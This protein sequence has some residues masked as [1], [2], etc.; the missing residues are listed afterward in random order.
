M[1]RR[2]LPL[3][4]LLLL[5]PV[6]A[7]ADVNIYD[8]FRD[9]VRKE[10]LEETYDS[11]MVKYLIGV[12]G[13]RWEFDE[14]RMKKALAG[15]ATE[16]CG[17]D[18]DSS[19][20]RP[21]ANGLNCGQAIG[22]IQVLAIEEQELRSF[23]RN[24]Q[25]IAAAQELPLSEIPGRPFHLATD[26]SGII[27]IWRAGTGSVR[28][29]VTGAVLLRTRPLTEDEADRL[30]EVWDQM[31]ERG[32]ADMDL[33]DAVG[34]V[35]WRYQYG[36]RLVKGERN[37]GYPPPHEDDQSGP[38]TERP[39]MFKDWQDGENGEIGW[40]EIL[41]R[42]W[43]LLPKSRDAFDPPLSGNEVAYFLFPDSVQSHMP[44]GTLLWA[45]VGAD[46]YE[47]GVGERDALG[48]VGLVW[49]YP[50]E[51]LLPALL[52]VDRDRFGEPILGGRYPPEPVTD[53][54]SDD[55]GNPL[56]PGEKAPAD[57][58]GLCSM[59]LAQRGYLCRK[60]TVTDEGRC[61]VDENAD[62]GENAISL[63][64]C[65]LEDKPTVTLAG[66]DVC[67]EITWKN[68][69]QPQQCRVEFYQGDCNGADAYAEP[70]TPD[71]LLRV[72]VKGG[73][74]VNLT[75]ILE[76]EL[77]H[78]QQFCSMPPG[79]I[80]AGLDDD[81]AGALCC[82]IEGEAYLANCKRMYDDG[83]LR[84][85]E[86][87]SAYIHGFELTPQICMELSRMKS[88]QAVLGREVKCESSGDFTT[89]DIE[90]LFP[91]LVGNPKNLPD[92]FETSTNPE[93]MDPRIA[94]RVRAIERYNPV[95]TPGTES[96]YKNTI[97][98]NACYVG[99]C[100]EESLETHRVTAGRSPAT[101]GDGAFPWDDPEMG[102]ALATTLR[103]VP[104][105]NPPLPSYRPQMVMRVLEDALCQLQ[106]MPAST[107]PHLCAFASSRRLQLPLENGAETTQSLVYGAQEQE[108]ATLLLRQIA[109]ALGSRI[110]T[111]MQGQYLRVGTRT[112][113]EV[114][115]L[116]NSLLRDTLGVRFPTNMCPMTLPNG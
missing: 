10:L 38:G 63:V 43:E 85:A 69:D 31:D 39:Y 99:Q 70:K 48:D 57:G 108:D 61:P 105:T 64:S 89:D 84:D 29:T 78:S 13:D 42:V 36:V 116:A 107:P 60:L 11:T 15:N 5:P 52:D 94:A 24:L 56:P 45:R 109:S 71:G 115:A 93:T 17:V 30:D 81:A 26:L 16:A 112:L 103:S 34:G 95:C 40:E 101:V 114:V 8:M 55:D 113:S 97:G 44:E 88:C 80:Y 76:H 98:N 90:E 1:I 46:G 7:A 68:G 91:Y 35:V 3:I 47:P 110:G 72:C 27:N 51:P 74:A 77:V 33:P 12:Y 73:L 14:E 4:G 59:A 6:A 49:K 86:G 53:A 50:V 37:P 23:G 9:Q 28:Q 32:V 58:R 104:V 102:T 62:D 22:N 18:A 65:T 111:D 2:Y 67:R 100:V 25:R 21:E 66:A 41:S 83:L 79:N 19:D 87:A 75:Y 20:D 82:R 54:S 92:D 106:G 96:S